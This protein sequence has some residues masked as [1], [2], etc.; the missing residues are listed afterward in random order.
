MKDSMQA[1]KS[2]VSRRT[3]E[4]KPA[5]IRLKLDE[6]RAQLLDLGIQLFSQYGYD[7][8]SIDALAEAAGVGKGLLY[9]Y[10]GSKREFYAAT[11]KAAS[12]HLLRLTAPD[13]SLPP[14]ERLGAAID[15]HL[16]Y[17]EAHKTVYLA[18]YRSGAAVAPEV[19]TIIEE[20]RNVILRY[21]LEGLGVAA[22]RPMLRMALRA[23]V[24][25]VEAAS[26]DWITRPAISRDQFKDFIV[27]TYMA[28]L[29]KAMELDPKITLN[30]PPA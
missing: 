1:R 3:P 5:R 29:G 21:F 30:R 15:K 17:L 19:G 12:M 7:D 10:F 28:M 22:P 26:L 25:M 2:H 14:T 24:A 13:L 18:M 8:I 27:D 16:Q 9:H 20:H 6:R 11:V 23:W 4:D